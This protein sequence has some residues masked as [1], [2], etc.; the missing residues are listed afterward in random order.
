M[1]ISP[2]HHYYIRASKNIQTTHQPLLQISTPYASDT[3]SFGQRI[4]TAEENQHLGEVKTRVYHGKKGSVAD[5]V[6]AAKVVLDEDAKIKKLK[7]KNSYLLFDPDVP[8]ELRNDERF[9][10]TNIFMFN[11]SQTNKKRI[12]KYTTAGVLGA[13]AGA[14]IAYIPREASPVANRVGSKFALAKRLKNP[15]PMP[16]VLAG[17]VIAFCITA[18][19]DYIKSRKNKKSS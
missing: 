5:Y 8:C 2:V 7:L 9:I 1:K 10:S 3:V 19:A 13:A 17:A 12:A 11:N 16:Y 4:V 18:L 15:R 6:E 14:G